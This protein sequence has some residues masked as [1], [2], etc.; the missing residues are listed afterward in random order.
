MATYKKD[1]PALKAREERLHKDLDGDGEK[2]ESPAHRAKVLGKKSDGKKD[3]KKDSPASTNSP[4]KSETKSS[5]STPAA[6]SDKKV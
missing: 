5:S 2:G 3:G 1:A 6:T 4:A